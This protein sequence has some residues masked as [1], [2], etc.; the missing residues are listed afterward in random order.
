MP[1]K[2]PLVNVHELRPNVFNGLAKQQ[3]KEQQPW[4]QG[5]LDAPSKTTSS[6]RRLWIVKLGPGV[7]VV[8]AINAGA[9]ASWIRINDK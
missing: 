6:D 1:R 3:K 8:N 2:K 5:E 9:Q 7:S 4:R